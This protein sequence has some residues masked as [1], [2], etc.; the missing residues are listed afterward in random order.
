MDFFNI[1]SDMHRIRN[2]TFKTDGQRNPS[3]ES[4]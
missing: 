3:E 1:F 2:W 4:S